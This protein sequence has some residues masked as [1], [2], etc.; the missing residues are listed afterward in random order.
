M[1]GTVVRAPRE[2]LA[3]AACGRCGSGAGAAFPSGTP[4]A[5]WVHSCTHLESL[6]SP[7]KRQV[8]WRAGT[9]PQ[10]LCGCGAVD[11]CAPRARAVRLLGPAPCL[12]PRRECDR[13]RAASC[14]A[15]RDLTAAG[16]WA[17]LE[18]R[19]EWGTGRSESALARPLACPA[20]P[21]LSLRG[22]GLRRVSVLCMATPSLHQRRLPLPGRPRR[23][24]AQQIPVEPG[25]Q[26][27]AGPRACAP[28]AEAQR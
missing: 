8:A 10:R 2:T 17:R 22:V 27:G 4:F 7:R 3:V 15:P 19:D 20:P 9:G 1:M 16:A 21:L 11:G 18:A 23:H 26:V 25:H 12:P 14:G 5:R 24:E 28:C 13:E 6:S